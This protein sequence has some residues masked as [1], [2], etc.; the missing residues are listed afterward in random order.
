MNFELLQDLFN[1]TATN[2][3][4]CFQEVTDFCTAQRD[5]LLGLMER[6]SLVLYLCCLMLQLLVK[7]VAVVAL[8][9]L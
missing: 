5:D 6:I 3:C 7:L 9:E 2:F 1:L 4:H 8:I